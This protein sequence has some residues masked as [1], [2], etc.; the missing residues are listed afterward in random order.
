M[1]KTTKGTEAP[2]QRAI[3][4]DRL[5]ARQLKCE[6]QYSNRKDTITC[7]VNLQEIVPETILH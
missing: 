3:I 1:E 6:P 4:P 7:L 2:L 5:H